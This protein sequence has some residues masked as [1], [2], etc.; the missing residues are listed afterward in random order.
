ME[1][2]TIDTKKSLYKPIRIKVDNEVFVAKKIDRD[3]IRKIEKLA[4]E[5]IK[6]DV[7]AAYKQLE[8]IFGKSKVL[9]NLDL[10]E[11][12]GILNHVT[13]QIYKSERTPTEPAKKA[14]GPGGAGSKK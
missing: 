9:D 11:V 13:Q 10:R 7:E 1:E 4:R 6:G 5:A 2:Y 3:A 12:N 14:N 8:I